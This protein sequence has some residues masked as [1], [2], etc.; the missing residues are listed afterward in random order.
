MMLDSMLTRLLVILLISILPL[1]VLF[2][3]CIYSFCP[4]VRTRHTNTVEIGRRISCIVCKEL[5]ECFLSQCLSWV[6]DS[7]TRPVEYETRTPPSTRW[8]CHRFQSSLSC[9]N[10]LNTKFPH[11]IIQMRMAGCKMHLEVEPRTLAWGRG[12]FNSYYNVNNITSYGQ[13]R[14]KKVCA[15]R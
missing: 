4:K 10:E 13:Q 9:L 2:K 14:E 1:S 6:Q 5:Y 3:K 8:L 11:S 12:G 7:N 15:C